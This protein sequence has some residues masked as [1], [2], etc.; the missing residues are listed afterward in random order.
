[1]RF[2]VLGPLAVWTDD[3]VP[4]RVR[5]TK[6]R[7]LL[8][9]LLL[10]EGRMV[11]AD[12][13]VDVLWGDSPPARPTAVLQARVS[14]LRGA[15]DRAEPGARALVRYRAPGYLL[16]ADDVDAV[17]FS[18]LVR[19]ARDGAEPRTRVDLLTRALDLWRG[20]AL[21]EFADGDAARPVVARW[22]EERVAAVEERAEALN[23]LGE[24]AVVAADLTDAV[25]RHP[26]RERLHAARITALY[27]AGRQGEALTAYERLRARLADELGVDPGPDLLA[28]HRAL[29]DQDPALG[30][31]PVAQAPPGNLPAPMG[32]L[33]G[34]EERL[35]QLVALAG[36]HR[37]VTLTGPGGVGKTRLALA[38]AER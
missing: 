18:A 37:L 26:F 33:V 27:G 14:Q 30:A 15:L 20:P 23:A 6:V 21:A 29:L 25:D 16:S 8:A 28:L 10:A 5:D 24:Y 7:A 3:G 31:V 13:L 1:M 35:G 2:G 12:H 38:A 9:A 34:R 4:V 17:R 22:E 32:D 19:R 11:T 36:E